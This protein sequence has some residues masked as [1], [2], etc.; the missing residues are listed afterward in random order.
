MIAKIGR[1]ANLYGALAYNLLKV[2]QKTATVL[3]AHKIIETPNGEYTTQGLTQSFDPYL[4]ANRKTEKCVLH[5]SLNPDP[6]DRVT[7]EMFMDLAQ[8]YMQGMGY[9]NQPFVVFKHLDLDRIHIHIVSVCVDQEGRKISD[10]FEKRRSMKLCRALEQKF[11]WLPALDRDQN[12]RDKVLRPIVYQAGDV[13]SQMAT[14]IRNLPTTYQ[15]QTFG[16]YQ[17]LLSL[18][19]ISCER[20]EGSHKGI[21]KKGL[22]YFALDDTLCKVGPAFKSSLFGKKAGAE[23]LEAHLEACKASLKGHLAK[24]Q[25]K[26]S[27]MQAKLESSNE[28]EFKSVLKNLGIDVVVRRSTSNRIYGITFIDHPSQTV[29]NGSHLAKELAANAFHSHWQDCTSNERGSVIEHG[30]PS[31]KGQ[32]YDESSERDLHDLFDFMTIPEG[33]FSKGPLVSSW[34][35]LPDFENQFYT[36]PDFVTLNKRKRKRKNKR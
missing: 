1:G 27:L 21:P 33:E 10:R 13:K 2:N 7:D 26:E 35:I 23:T 3:F 34:S 30:I 36:A 5:I 32:A 22:V 25:I 19:H 12:Q 20:I 17:A 31:G 29:W 18:F 24:K 4:F 15:Y 14:V 8:L 9:G 16:E 28:S 6:K 11:G